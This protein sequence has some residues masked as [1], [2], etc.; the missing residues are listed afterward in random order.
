MK[1]FNTYFLAAA[2][3]LSS[4]SF[5]QS[6]DEELRYYDVE[7]IIFKNVQVPKSKE[8]ILPVSLPTKDAEV[9]DLTSPRSI[10]AASKKSYQITST[11]NLRLLD[12]AGKIIKSPYY[13]LLTHIGWRQPGLE[14]GQALPV[15]I[16]GGRTY[17]D[18]YVSI[19]SQLGSL[20]SDSNNQ[21]NDQTN[22][23]TSPQ[24]IR[25]THEKLYELEGKVTVSL[26]RY[27]HTYADLILRR[28]RLSLDQTLDNPELAAQLAY[29][30]DTRILDNH[31]LKE[32]RR[33]RSKSLHY[34]DSP[35]FSLL[36]LITPVE[37]AA[38]NTTS[39]ETS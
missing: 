21:F 32:H 38:I 19:D 34:L 3:L 11:K 36:V 30:P 20:P 23:S 17:G 22:L 5:A 18:E 10:K 24:L 4:Q 25:G 31:S 15:W 33:M 16:Q 14:K 12:K 35:E 37:K 26:S 28:P 2:M 27:L 6:D 7:I 8:F 9:L 13:E 1:I 39:A 29:S